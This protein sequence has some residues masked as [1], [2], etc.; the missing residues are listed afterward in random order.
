M[1]LAVY[2]EK[3]LTTG[4]QDHSASDIFPGVSQGISYIYNAVFGLTHFLLCPTSFPKQADCL[5]WFLCQ[6]GSSKP[7]KLKGMTF[8][9]ISFFCQYDSD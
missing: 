7:K 5:E 8:Y 3:G 1:H 6:A 2:S 9:R 4:S